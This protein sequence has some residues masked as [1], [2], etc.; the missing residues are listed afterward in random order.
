MVLVRTV[1]SFQ[2]SIGIRETF[3]SLNDLVAMLISE[4]HIGADS[5]S[6]K[7]EEQAF[8]SNHSR[9]RGHGRYGK[10]RGDIIMMPMHVIQIT[11]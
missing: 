3:P 7:N 5:S 1:Q 10:G 9:G 4:L 6:N 11:M 2:T 8:Y